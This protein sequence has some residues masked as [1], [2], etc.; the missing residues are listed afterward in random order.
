VFADEVVGVI[1]AVDD[2]DDDDSGCC[3]DT[4][5]VMVIRVTGGALPQLASALVAVVATDRCCRGAPRRDRLAVTG[6]ITNGG[7]LVASS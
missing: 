4:L 7:N 6:A 2:D 1:I 5:L 3:S